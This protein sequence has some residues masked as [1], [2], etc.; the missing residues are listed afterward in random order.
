MTTMAKSAAETLA[1]N[2]APDLVTSGSAYDGFQCALNA[3][4]LPKLEQP[5]LSEILISLP[6][7]YL[8]FTARF[9]G[10]TSNYEWSP[11]LAFLIPA[12]ATATYWYS[13]RAVRL[14]LRLDG[15]YFARHALECGFN[16][17]STNLPWAFSVSDPRLSALGQALRVELESGMPCGRLYG[18]GIREA[19]C[20]HLNWQYACKQEGPILGTLGELRLSR[21]IQFINDHLAEDLSI[22]ALANVAGYSPWH[23]QRLFKQ[24]IGQPVHSY[25][26][27]ARTHRAVEMLGKG[28]TAELAA[29]RAG[30]SH[31]SHLTRWMLRLHGLRLRD[32]K[33]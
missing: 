24:S 28:L 22:E 29:E 31:R 27:R 30:F 4:H 7:N 5:E 11:D 21:V 13:Q 23:F 8:S 33:K 16:T 9:D 1:G 12:G 20:A 17:S 15:A 18:E 32:F 14:H 25:V 6:Q 2:G 19:I 10:K 26:V 3:F